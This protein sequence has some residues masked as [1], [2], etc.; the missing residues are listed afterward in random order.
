MTTTYLPSP[1]G[2]LRII[3]D[4]IGVSAISCSDGPENDSTADALP[5]PVEQA[6]SQ[7]REYFTGSRR[8]FDF[9]MTPVGTA[10]QQA[11]WRALRTVPFGT[12]Q[13]YLTLTRSLG[14]TPNL[15][16]RNVSLDTTR[17]L[18]LFSCLRSPAPRATADPSRTTSMV[19]NSSTPVWKN[20]YRAV[21]WNGYSTA[22][23]ARGPISPTRS[24][25]PNPRLASTATA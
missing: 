2:T 23:K 5:E 4:V 19:R 14:V 10:F 1:L 24:W 17:S 11:V 7:L 16:S 13:S 6:V 21:C 20:V 3:G 8:A 9:P 22:T 18:L 25:D 15:F 12:T